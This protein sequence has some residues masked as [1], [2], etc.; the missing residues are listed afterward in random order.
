MVMELGV[1]GG[2]RGQGGGRGG[3][4]VAV[5]QLVGV[6]VAVRHL[7]RVRVVAVRQLVVGLAACLLASA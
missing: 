1:R 4:G 5:R 3:A 7:V 6:A 2:L